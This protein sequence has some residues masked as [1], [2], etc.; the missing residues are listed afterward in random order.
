MGTAVA[1]FQQEAEER[2]IRRRRSEAY[3]RDFPCGA[4]DRNDWRRR[5][6]SDDER[7]RPNDDAA[8][9]TP[10]YFG[11]EHDGADSADGGQQ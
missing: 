10:E 5:L 7:Q 11:S 2:I 4:V 8:K 1:S 6:W 3:V 9:L